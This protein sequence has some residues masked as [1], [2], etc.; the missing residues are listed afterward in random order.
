MNGEEYLSKKSRSECSAA[1]VAQWASNNG[2]DTSG[3]AEKRVGIVT[4]FIRHAIR[5]VPQGASDNISKEVSHI[6]AKIRWFEP[7]PSYLHFGPS[8]LV[9]AST[10]CE[11]KCNFYSNFENKCTMCL[12]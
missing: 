7:H 8:V 4:S 6:L 9:V 3:K 11:P 5:I 1:I 12:L 2:I 10:F